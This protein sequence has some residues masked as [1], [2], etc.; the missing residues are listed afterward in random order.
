MAGPGPDIF[1]TDEELGEVLM[2]PYIEE[3]TRRGPE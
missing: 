1:P 2:A 3:I